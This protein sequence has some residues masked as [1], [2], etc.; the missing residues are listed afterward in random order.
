MNITRKQLEALHDVE[1]DLAS[2]SPHLA[3]DRIKIHAVLNSIDP[4]PH[5]SRIDLIIA[6]EQG[7]LDDEAAILL[8]QDMI[9]D[10]TVWALQGSYGRMA[11]ALI[12]QGLCS[13]AKL[14][15]CQDESQSQSTL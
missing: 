3:E 7:E 11:M 15:K 8:F 2:P 5:M 1:R 14:D 12:R 10:G 9:D 13:P 4:Q 6:F